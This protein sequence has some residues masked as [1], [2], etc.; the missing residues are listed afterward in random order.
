MA[1]GCLRSRKYPCGQSRVS[2]SEAEEG[3]MEK[4]GRLA[5]VGPERRGKNVGV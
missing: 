4:L 3:E 5:R 1:E 2:E